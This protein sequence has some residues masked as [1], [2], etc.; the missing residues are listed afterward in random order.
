MRNTSYLFFLIVLYSACNTSN[1]KLDEKDSNTLEVSYFGQA[2]P[3]LTAK[4]F[5]PDIVSVKG[6]YEY[7]VSFSPKID[8]MYFSANKEDEAQ[9][10]YF[11]RRNGSTWSTPKIANFTNGTKKNEL[12]AFVAPDG[13][14]IF[15]TAYDSIFHDENIWFVNRLDTSWSTAKKI[16]SPINNDLVFYSN[17]AENGDLYYTSIS[18]WKMYF[19]PNTNGNYATVEE[20]DIDFGGH[21]FISSSQDFIL[22][23]APKN[24]DSNQNSDIHVCFKEKDGTWT[25]PIPL[26]EEVNTTFSE[27]CPSLSPDGKYLFFSRYN[28]QGGLSNIYWV[29]ASVIDK[30]KPNTLHR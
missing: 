14:K 24:N 5:A 30:V 16:E 1:K 21:G 20:L 6:R 28:E 15:F 13:K 2:A 7:A 12:E 18:K 19:A 25:K 29:S 4:I 11:S 27:T 26:G 22:V 9:N 3:G 23:D 10:V 8:E 17:A